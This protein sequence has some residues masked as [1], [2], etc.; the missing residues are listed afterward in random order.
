MPVCNEV[1]G[2]AKQTSTATDE[3]SKKINSIQS[4]SCSVVEF[5]SQL[6]GIVSSIHEHQ[7]MIATTITEQTSVSRE[8]SQ[9]IGNTSQRSES[10][11]GHIGNLV[12]CNQS[13]LETM[14][15]TRNATKNVIGCAVIL[16]NMLANYCL[17]NPGFSST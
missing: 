17:D 13:T 6:S 1:K 3:I 14:D 10:I 2:L 7:T 12:S 15:Q 8:I 5:T 11:R 4:D 16:E 9:T